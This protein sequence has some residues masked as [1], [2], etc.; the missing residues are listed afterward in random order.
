VKQGRDK[1]GQAGVRRRGSDKTKKE[2]GWGGARV[3]S[4]EGG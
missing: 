3:I 4:K 1:K 2:G